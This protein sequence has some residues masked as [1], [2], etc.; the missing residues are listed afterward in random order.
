MKAHLFRRVLVG[1]ANRAGASSEA[2][3][4]ETVGSTIPVDVLDTG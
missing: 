1:Y 3:A 4:A 2:A